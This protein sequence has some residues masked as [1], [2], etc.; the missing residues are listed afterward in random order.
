[1]A[2][3][4]SWDRRIADLSER[5]LKPAARSRGN[6]FARKVSVV[7]TVTP[8][9]DGEG[10]LNPLEVYLDRHA[11]GPGIW[12]WRHYFEAYHRHLAKFVGQEV[13]VVEIGVYSGGSLDMWRSY[14]GSDSCI[15]GV[16]IEEACKA[17][18]RDGVTIFVGDQ[19]DYEFWRA[20]CRDVPPVDVV[21]DDG[22]HE[23][24]QQIVTLESLLPHMRPGGVYLCEDIH[25]VE[26]EFAAYASALVANLNAWQTGGKPTGFQSLV[27][28]IHHYPFLTVIEKPAT[29]RE[30]F[31]APK[32]GTQWQPFY[33]SY[34]SPTPGGDQQQQAASSESEPS[35]F[36]VFLWLAGRWGR[37]AAWLLS[38][39][40]HR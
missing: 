2:Q 6:L 25:G 31:T 20:F 4:P 26:N 40:R 35:T 23:P 5:V 27:H 3:R 9:E 8:P 29:R 7:S 17:Y 34:D 30:S 33:N 24:Q 13:R 37:R 18:E 28:S 32:R 1:M 21:I 12:K 14:F 16:D 10:L 15:Y 39:P 38:R 22:G 19:G 11:E 36:R